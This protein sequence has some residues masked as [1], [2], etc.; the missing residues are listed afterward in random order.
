MI[1]VGEDVRVES[2]PSR[3][4]YG[5]E[6]ARLWECP[7]EHCKSKPGSRNIKNIL[8]TVAL[9]LNQLSPQRRGIKLGLD[10]RSSHCLAFR[11]CSAE[12]LDT[13]AHDSQLVNHLQVVNLVTQAGLRRQPVTR[14]LTRHIVSFDVRY[15][16]EY[17]HAEC[18]TVPQRRASDEINIVPNQMPNLR[19]LSLS[20]LWSSIAQ[21]V[22]LISGL[23]DQLTRLTLSDCSVKVNLTYQTSNNVAGNWMPVFR[24][25]ALVPGLENL[26]LERLEQHGPCDTHELQFAGVGGDSDIRAVWF[27]RDQ[28]RKGLES[29]VRAECTLMA[30]PSDSAENISSR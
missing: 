7:G 15:I 18:I 6:H 11:P 17:D 30:T 3:S 21:F 26:H 20:G 22:Q 12:E 1:L 13:W 28:V 9:A 10:L 23:R 8:H 14:Y 25:L 29:L 27:T 19:W 2:Q 4:T 16:G 24:E 5:V